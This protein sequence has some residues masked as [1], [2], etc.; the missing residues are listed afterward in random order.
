MSFEIDVLEQQIV[1]YNSHLMDILLQ[2]HTTGQNIKWATDDY[3]HLGRFYDA[4]SEIKPIQIT[5]GSTLVIQPRASKTNREQNRRTKNKAEVFTPSWVCNEQNN[6]IDEAWFGRKEVFN[7]LID[8]NDASKG[9]ETYKRRIDFP[10]ERGRTWQDY[11]DERRL[12]IACGEAPYLV[13]RYDTVSGKSIPVIERIG[14][15]DRKLRIINENAKDSESW[16]KWVIRAYESTYGFEYQGDNVLLAREN[17]LYTYIDN[18]I[19]RFGERPALRDTKKIATIV[20]WNI[21]QMNGITMTAP[22]SEHKRA[23]QFKLCID[24]L[25]SEDAGEENL[26]SIEDHTDEMPCVVMDWRSKKKEEFRSIVRGEVY[27]K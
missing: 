19:E 14:L 25:L 16:K 8:S 4:K 12:E 7:A 11:V 21:W 1:E 20:S 24:A 23:E 3:S 18:Y 26:Y 22:F 13:S 6:L 5:G 27:G 17:L 10:N 9:W 15:L 2:D